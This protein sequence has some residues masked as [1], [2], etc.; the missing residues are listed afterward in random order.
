MF[1]VSKQLQGQW[2]LQELYLRPLAGAVWSQSW[3]CKRRSWWSGSTKTKTP[4]IIAKGRWQGK[5]KSIQKRRFV[6]MQCLK[7][8]IAVR[9]TA[10]RKTAL[11]NSTPTN[12]SNFNHLPSAFSF[13]FRQVNAWPGHPST[14][15]AW[16]WAAAVVAPAQGKLVL[17]TS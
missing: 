5:N 1:I 7:N 11:Q 3:T 16:Q 10:I 4:P 12:S 17:S 15:A 2:E 9:K 8:R 6:E 13:A 14:T